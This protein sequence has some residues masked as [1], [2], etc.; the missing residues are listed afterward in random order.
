MSFVVIETLYWIL[1]CIYCGYVKLFPDPFEEAE[2]HQ[3][4]TDK[5]YWHFALYTEQQH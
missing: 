5:Y 3:R 2:M 1:N 4:R